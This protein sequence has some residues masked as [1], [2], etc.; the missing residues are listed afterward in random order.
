MTKSHWVTLCIPFIMGR[1]SPFN[2]KA[3]D[4]SFKLHL[5]HIHAEVFRDTIDKVCIFLCMHQKEKMDQ[6][7]NSWIT[8]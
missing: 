7:M 4:C 2:I 3:V 5:L 6:E 1:R 8:G